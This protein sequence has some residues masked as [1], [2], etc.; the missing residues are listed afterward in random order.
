MSISSIFKSMFVPSVE[1]EAHRLAYHNFVYEP[2]VADE[3]RI[4]ERIDLAF[5]G[6]CEDFA[7]TLQIQI[8]GDVWYVLLPNKTAH[9]V[10][11]IGDKCYCNRYK[12]PISKS[13]YHGE[14]LFVMKD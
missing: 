3:R 1:E 14:F 4:Y 10:L 9:A 7:F 13:R 2:D 5:K 11:V 12:R 8:G 6:D